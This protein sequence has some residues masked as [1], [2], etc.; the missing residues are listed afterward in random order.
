MEV[1]A[2]R[3]LSGKLDPSY[4][5]YSVHAVAVNCELVGDTHHKVIYDSARPK[6]VVVETME[7]FA[8]SLVSM[9]DMFYFEIGLPGVRT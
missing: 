7:D 5:Q 4:S 1:E 3:F 9:W 2:C 6:R 8:M